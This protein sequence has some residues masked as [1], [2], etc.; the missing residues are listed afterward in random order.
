[1]IHSSKKAGELVIQLGFSGI[2]KRVERILIESGLRVPLAK[3][4]RRHEIPAF[5]G[6]RRFFNK[7]NKNN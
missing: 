2:R 6:F 4:Q 7:Q 3:G 1:M 5:N